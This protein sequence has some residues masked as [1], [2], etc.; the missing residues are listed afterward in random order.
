MKK[1]YW[2]LLF[3]SLVTAGS[4]KVQAQAP[5]N[6]LFATSIAPIIY[7]NCSPCHREGAIAGFMPFTNYRQ[8]RTHAMN[9][10]QAVVTRHMPPWPPDPNYNKLAYQRSLS[11]RQ[12]NDIADWV[13]NNMP[14]GD[15]TL[16]PPLPTFPEFHPVLGPPDTVIA[17]AKAHTIQ[18][19]YR[20][21]Y[22]NFVIPLNL[23]EDKDVMAIEFVPGN[24]KVAHHAILALDTL[25]RG[26]QLDAQ[27]TVYGWGS[28]GGG[29]GFMPA[30]FFFATWVPG[31]NPTILPDGVANKMWKKSDIVV[32][33]HYGPTLQ[34]QKDS[35]FIRIYYA[36]TPARRYIQSTLISPVS[37][38]PTAFVI[39]ANTVQSFTGRN[40]INKKVSFVDIQP[41]S[42]LL[43]KSWKSFVVQPNGDTTRLINI[44]KWDFHWQGSYLFPKFVK[45]DS[46]ASLFAT[47]V[48]DNTV[49][50]P[51]NPFNPPVGSRWG[52]ETEN[53]MFLLGVTYVDYE[54]GDEFINLERQVTSNLERSQSFISAAEVF[55]NPFNDELKLKV[56]TTK[57]GKLT[58]RILDLSGREV[59]RM[60]ERELTCTCNN[61]FSWRELQ[62]LKPGLYM[63]E[64]RVADG[65]PL[66]R[67]VY[68]W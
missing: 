43:T 2:F 24:T 35:S 1:I 4:Y 38:W 31:A 53:E 25:R 47:A 64:F 57:T 10:K 39:P 11:D 48:Y 28:S 55:P 18:G 68:K 21:E 45:V 52:E 29:F 3:F 58:G 23:S 46:G 50:N 54:E 63:V 42:H 67:K 7:Q 65:S 22:R 12:I 40:R 60:S 17:M 26:R 51:N 56:R 27:D 6:P 37:L 36:R 13:T 20:D 59:I 14:R 15:S 5:N 61:E 30:N 66:L 16:E 44:P 33:M 32:Q 49:N 62:G 41:H 9:I 8:V 19:N 34:T